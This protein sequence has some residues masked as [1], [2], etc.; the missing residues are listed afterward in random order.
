MFADKI[1]STRGVSNGHWSFSE[2]LLKFG[3][4]LIV[5]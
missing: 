5:E 2:G 3:S 4:D 1:H